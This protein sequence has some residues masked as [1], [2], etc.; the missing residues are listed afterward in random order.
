VE[1]KPLW[2][3]PRCGARLVS[4]N[5]SHSCGQFTLEAL[6]AD[7]APR[8]LVL[9]RAYVAMLH[10]LGDVRLHRWLDSPRVVRTEDYGPNWRINYVA[11]ATLDDLDDELRGWL[12]ESHDTVG[13]QRR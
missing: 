1:P 12:Q 6:F 5:L 11:I 9:A 2:T 4:R 7:A 8:V 10:I 3:C 13:L